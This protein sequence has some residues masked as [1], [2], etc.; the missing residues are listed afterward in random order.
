VILYGFENRSF[1]F[2]EAERLRIF[3]NRVTRNIFYKRYEV[4]GDWRRL[5]IKK[6]IILLLIRYYLGDQSR[7]A[8]GAGH[9]EH[10][11]KTPY[12]VLVGKT[13]KQTH[14]KT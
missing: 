5:H 11:V 9:L 6:F 10:K 1:T 12:W 7:I 8:R 14:W 3:A 4:T 2:W 13:E